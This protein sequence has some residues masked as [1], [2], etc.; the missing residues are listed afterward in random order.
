M[1]RQAG[2]QAQ[3]FSSRLEI[4]GKPAEGNGFCIT[5]ASG[6]CHQEYP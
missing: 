2:L 6:P 1:I 4:A 3:L 5:P